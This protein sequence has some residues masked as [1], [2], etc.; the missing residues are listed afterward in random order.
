MEIYIL[1]LKT[2]LSVL[3]ISLLGAGILYSVLLLV[4]QL[5]VKLTRKELKKVRRSDIKQDI[6]FEKLKNDL[7]H[8]RQIIEN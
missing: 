4:K 1:A 6:D 2:G 7:E 8:W 3:T 5:L